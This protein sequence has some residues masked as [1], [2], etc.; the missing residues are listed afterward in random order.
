MRSGRRSPIS[1]VNGVS[2]CSGRSVTSRQTKRRPRF[3]S[4]APGTSRASARTWKPLQIPST[5]PPRAAKS[6]TARITGEKRAMTPAR[7]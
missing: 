1:R 7:R 6:A 2:M 3:R 4:S 5:G